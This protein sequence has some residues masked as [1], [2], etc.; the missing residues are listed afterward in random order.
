MV[1]SRENGRG[2][3]HAEGMPV[4]VRHDPS[5]LRWLVGVEL[6][7]FRDA[8]GYSLSDVATMT[9]IT[10]PKLGHLESGRQGQDPDDIAT[11]LAAYDTD[12]RDIDRLTTL[13]GQANARSW[14]APWAQVVPD[15]VKTFIGLEGLAVSEFVFEPVLIPGLLQTEEYARALTEASGFVRVDHYERFVSFRLARATRLTDADEPLSL[16]TV[17]TEAAL[18]LAVGGPQLRRAQC[19]HLLE[20]AKLPNVTVQILCPSDGPHAAVT[21]QFAVLDFELARS[22]AYAELLDGAVYVQDPDQIRTYTV[23][24][25]NLRQVALSPEK[26]TTLINALLRAG[27]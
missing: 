10:K 13:A 7:R 11:V 25:D 27:D 4:P 6:A 2:S 14:W 16:H 9:G 19:R 8:A 1:G 26:S 20:L 24:T 18:R 3:M 17:F 23:A 22:I 12:R 15:W 21:G 5:A